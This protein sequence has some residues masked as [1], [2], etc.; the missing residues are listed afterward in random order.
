LWPLDLGTIIPYKGSEDIRSRRFKV[1]DTRGIELVNPACDRA[2]F[3]EIERCVAD[4]A[5]AALNGH[6]KV[7][8]EQAALRAFNRAG[9]ITTG[10]E[11]AI[12]WAM[13][14]RYDREPIR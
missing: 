14:D 11:D 13:G 1:A 4:L 3:N 8:R 9:I 6:D 10:R 2:I 7:E 5:I 12:K